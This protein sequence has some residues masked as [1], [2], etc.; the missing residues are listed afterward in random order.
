MR[1]FD[2][3][4]IGGGPG[5]SDCA[6]RLA[7]RGKKV[8]IVEKKHFGGTCTNVGCIPTKGLLYV[9]GLYAGIKEKGKR[10][11]LS[12]ELSYD[13]KGMKKHMERSILMSRKGTEALL[14]KYGVAIIK[15]T[16]YFDRGNFYVEE[17][18][19]ELKGDYYVIATGSQPKIPATLRVEGVWNS[20]DVFTMESIP[21]SIVIIGGGVIGIE[22]ATLFSNLGSS[23]TI[24][25]MM[26]RLLPNEDIDVSK[27]IEK[28]LTRRGIKVLLST[29][30]KKIEKSETFNI[31]LNNEME[32]SSE[33]VLVAIGREPV[34]PK[35]LEEKIDT[36]K[37]AI[38]TDR[39]FKSSLPNVYAI[40]DAR[41]KVMLA[42]VASAEG[43]Y[44]AEKL[45]GNNP[46]IDFN[47]FPSVVYS[48]PEVA[49]VG[50]KE[51]EDGLKDGLKSFLFPM[52]ANGR[53]NTMGERD[54]F[55][56]LV[57]DAKGTIV[58]GSLVGAHVS[59]TLMELVLAIKKRMTLKDLSEVIHPHPTISE[60]IRDAVEGLE[61]N[62]LHI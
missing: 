58:G 26:N 3:V 31:K 20:D 16:A 25:E 13:L 40:G 33:R 43:V 5:G 32:F 17:S 53:A 38:I 62:P 6:I 8:A 59:E 29:A 15:G 23:V 44:V 24:V 2:V 46:E 14:K 30:V 50:L 28:S 57:V 9:S 36:D 10:L 41:G 60:A 48:T 51:E 55:V 11:G 21:Q 42:H 61:G 12:G 22:M 37:G 4:V 18:G 45:S 52:S 39:D 27:A 7:Q 35:G 56:K 34:I 49:S 54:G 19:E 1:K 47:A